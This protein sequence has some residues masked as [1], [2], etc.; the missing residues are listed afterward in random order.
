MATR[1]K[2]EYKGEPYTLEYNR[3]TVRRL[4]NNGFSLDLLE[5]NPLEGIQRLFQGAFQVNH[6]R[7]PINQMEEIY[8]FFPNKE[9]LVQ[10]LAR[11]YNEPLEFL[12]E[13]PDDSVKINWVRED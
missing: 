11:M 8:N 4:A 9:E 5:H 7:T 3:K 12:V 1:I 6:S 13:E 10:T 2:F